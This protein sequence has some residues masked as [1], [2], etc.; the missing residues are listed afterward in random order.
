MH[1]VPSELIQTLSDLS[2]RDCEQALRHP[3]RF[4][5]PPAVFIFQPFLEGMEPGGPEFLLKPM[6]ADT[7]PLAWSMEQALLG[8]ELE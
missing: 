4:D 8:L 7:G 2:A 3:R 5:C 6:K 1:Q